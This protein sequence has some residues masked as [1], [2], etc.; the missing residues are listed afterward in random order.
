[1]EIKKK[2]NKD[3]LYFTSDSHFHHK[4]IVEY[5][6]R[7]WGD[8]QT[9]D[10]ALIAL[11]N[12]VVPKD[13]TV[14]HGGDFIFTG[15][16]EYTRELVD[17]LNGTIYLTLGNHDYKNSLN[18]EVFK[19]IFEDVQ[20]IY[21]ITVEDEELE[22]NCMNIQICHYPLYYWRSGYVHLHGHI[23]SGPRSTSN[24]K[25]SFH[26]LR[27]DIGIDNNDYKPISYHD[28]KVIL[29]KRQI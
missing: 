4:N 27:Y 1:M 8:V 26:P 25:L 21:Y 16:I 29:T 2:F 6:N 14:F 24:E 15:N 20:D 11:W 19:T 18:R 17:K 12:S 7:P 13:A 22:Y 9:Q 23:H 28:L 5:C 10:S 3:N